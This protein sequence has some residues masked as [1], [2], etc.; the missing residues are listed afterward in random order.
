MPRAIAPRVEKSTDEQWETT[1]QAVTW[2]KVTAPNGDLRQVKVGGRKGARF[3]ISFDDRV[4]NQDEI[5]VAEHD[6]FTNGLLFR[7]KG[8]EPVYP[9]QQADDADYSIDALDKPKTEAEQMMAFADLRA[10]LGKHG[11]AFR[12]SIARL[13]EVNLRRL[14]SI[15]EDLPEHEQ[16]TVA[17]QGALKE[18]MAGY[19][20]GGQQ[21]SYAEFMRGSTGPAVSAAG[22]PL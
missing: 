16:P 7:L 6:P 13:N 8:T 3:K 19:K 20:P 9:P 15:A 12:A 11:N 17:Q 2:I 21:K 5:V 4:A 22:T 18:L 10:I 14:I 1:T